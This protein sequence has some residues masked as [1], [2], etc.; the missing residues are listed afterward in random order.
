VSGGQS[1][2]VVEGFSR[3]VHIGSEGRQEREIRM[4][5]EVK[6]IKWRKRRHELFKISNHSR[7]EEHF[8]GKCPEKRMIFWLF[9]NAYRQTRISPLPLVSRLA[10]GALR[11]WKTEN[12][13][14]ITI[15]FSH[16]WLFQGKYLHAIQARRTLQQMEEKQEWEKRVV[17]RASE[18]GKPA[19]PLKY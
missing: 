9:Y 15:L 7:V 18:N 3:D 5:T 2:E 1:S 10:L 11:T 17:S 16:H 13:S 12:R 19:L 6:T 14:V 8:L 4:Q